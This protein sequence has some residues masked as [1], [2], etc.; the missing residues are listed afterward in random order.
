MTPIDPATPC[1]TDLEY[2]PEFVVLFAQVAA[3]VDAQYGDFVGTPEPVNWSEV[4]R[5]CR[6]LMIRSKDIRLGVLFTRC[7]TRLDSARGLAE[8]LNLLA[9]WLEDYPESVHPQPNVDEDK[10]AA[11]EIR[12]NAL[13][14]LTDSDGLLG[15]IR[16]IALARSSAVRLRVRDVERAYA[17]PRPSDALSVESVVRQLGDVRVHQP[18]LMAAFEDAANSLA[19]IDAWNQ[20]H[21]GMF[22]ADLALLLRLLGRMTKA[23][24]GSSSTDRG[25][26]IDPASDADAQSELIAPAREADSITTT[27]NDA[28]LQRPLDSPP[29]R[30]LTDRDAA[31]QSI[32]DARQWFETWEPSSPIPVLLLRAEQFV[33]KRYSEVLKAIPA[34]LMLEWDKEA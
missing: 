14:A 30:Q 6:R 32:R 18:A 31:L 2:D 24:V 23:A 20:T 9:R 11:L 33:G 15:D 25:T 3:K 7:R 29:A 28:D 26:H 19:A 4:D 13:Q 34:E 1:G 12:M 8:G 17:Q 22:A 27:D 16:D 5:D 21:L 10:D